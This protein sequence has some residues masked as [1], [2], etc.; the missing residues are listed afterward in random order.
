MAASPSKPDGTR[1]PRISPLLYNTPNITPCCCL[2]TPCCCLI[3]PFSGYIIEKLRYRAKKT[4]YSMTQEQVKRLYSTGI[5][6]KKLN[7]MVYIQKKNPK[8]INNYVA[9]DDRPLGAQGHSMVVH[10]PVCDCQA[11]RDGCLVG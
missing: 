10:V 11:G 3:T 4:L 2:I 8:K 7:S 1:F 5:E 9:V 6:Q